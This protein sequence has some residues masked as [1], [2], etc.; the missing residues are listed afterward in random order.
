MF[1]KLMKLVELDKTTDAHCQEYVI[2]SDEDKTL[3]DKAVKEKDRT[4]PVRMSQL[5]ME[6]T[7]KYFATEGLE[8]LR[9]AALELEEQKKKK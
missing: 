3:V 2:L 4:F 9:K 8:E 7:V 1:K 5:D 6:H